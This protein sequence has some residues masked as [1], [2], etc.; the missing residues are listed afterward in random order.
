MRELKAL[1]IN[2]IF[3]LFPA[4]STVADWRSFLDIAAEE[5]MLVDLGMEDGRHAGT[6]PT[7]I[8][9]VRDAVT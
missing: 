3:Q 5:G 4:D 8:R 6:V 1:D 7:L 9:P 2:I